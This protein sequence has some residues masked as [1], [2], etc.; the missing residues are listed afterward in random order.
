MAYDRTPLGRMIIYR[1][2]EIAVRMKNIEEAEEYY[3]E[4]HLRII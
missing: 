1:L 3:D 4:L 2:A